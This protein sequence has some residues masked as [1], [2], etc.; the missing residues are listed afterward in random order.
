MMNSLPIERVVFSAE[1]IQNRVLELGAQISRDYEGKS[2]HMIGV[3]RG[4]LPF[5]ADLA[6]AIDLPTITLDFLRVRRHPGSAPELLFDLDSSL[7]GRHVLLVEDL[8]AEGETLAYLSGLL[9]VR[10]PASL[11]LCSLLRRSTNVELA[12][13]GWDLHEQGY[14]VGYGLDVNERGRHLP[15][16]GVAAG[17]QTQ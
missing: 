11:R 13:W 15:Y 6:R 3:L 9:T 10:Q 1:Q 12:Y 7:A 2:L 4:A 16:I 8:V 5:M 14:L 17:S